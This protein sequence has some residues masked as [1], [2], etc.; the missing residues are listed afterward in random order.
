MNAPY[1]AQ[2]SSSHE[3]LLSKLGGQLGGPFGMAWGLKVAWKARV[4]QP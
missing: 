4:Y 2:A 3:P 1:R